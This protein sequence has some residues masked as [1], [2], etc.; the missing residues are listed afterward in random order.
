MTSKEF[1]SF[2]K[3]FILAIDKLPN[4]KQWEI[5]LKNL[6]KVEDDASVR[7]ITE[8]FKRVSKDKKFPGAPPDVYM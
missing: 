5:I 6:E 1:T 4:K 3:G 7:I 8:E 2:L